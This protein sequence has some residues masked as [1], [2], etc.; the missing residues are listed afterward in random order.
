MAPGLAYK[1]LSHFEDSIHFVHLT[2]IHVIMQ[3]TGF[4][5][6]IPTNRRGL[7]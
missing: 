2:D 3:D 7:C 1:T 5:E 6:F 4:A